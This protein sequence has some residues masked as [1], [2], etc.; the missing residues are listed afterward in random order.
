M[1][2]GIFVYD[3]GGHILQMNRAARDLLGLFLTKRRGCKKGE[4]LLL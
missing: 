2:D 3:K 1:T 4:K